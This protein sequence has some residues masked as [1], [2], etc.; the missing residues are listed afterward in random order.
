MEFNLQSKF[1]LKTILCALFTLFSLFSF[2]QPGSMSNNTDCDGSYGNNA[3]TTVGVGSNNTVFTYREQANATTSSGTKFY[4]FNADGYFNVWNLNTPTYN[5]VSTAVWGTGGYNGTIKMGATVSSSYYTFN[6]RKGTSYASQNMAILETAFLPQNITAVSVPSN[7]YG[8]QTAT[9]SVTMSG[10]LNSSE[11]LYVA[12]STDAFATSGN[13]GCVA[14]GAL[15]GSFVGNATIPAQISGTV[16]YYAFSSTS[17]S[18]PSF[19]NIP[20]LTLNMRNATA[21]NTSAAYASYTIQPWTTQTGATTFSAGSSWVGGVAP[22]AGVNIG[23]L[24]INH[25]LALDQDIIS[26][27]VAIAN[28]T[29][30]TINNGSTLQ[31]A[32]GITT[33]GTGSLLVNG[34]LQ[35]NSGGFSNV[36]PTYG[37]S[38]L[39]KYNSGTSYGRGTEWSATTGAGYPN[40]VQINNSTTLNLGANAG[41]GTARQCSGNL[42]IN[43]GSTLSMNE[44][45]AVMTAALTVRGDVINNGTITL[46]G[47]GG[48]DLILFGNLDD[49]GS[50]FA[51]TRA[52]FFDGSNTQT[53]NSSTDP[54]DIDVMRVR[55][56]GGEIILAQNLVVDET[57]DPFQVSTAASVINLNGKN[58]TI[59]KSG[60]TSAIS[61]ISGSAIKCNVASS[62]II[63]GNGALGTLRFDPSNNTLRNLTIN[64]GTSRTVT[65]GSALN[66]TSGSASGI[67]TVG[68]GSTLNTGGFLTLK[69]DVSGTASIGNS[70][71]TISGDVTAERYISGA[72][73]KWRFLSTPVVGQTLANWGSQF[74]ITGPGTAGATI[75]SANSNGFATTR[76]NLL[77]IPTTTSSVRRYVESTAGDLNVGWTDLGSNTSASLT[78]GVG[79]RVFIRGPI[80][81]NYSIDTLAIGSSANSQDQALFTLNQTGSITNTVNAGT[82]NLPVTFT[83][84]NGTANDGWNLVGNPYPSNID[85]NASGWTKTAV[86]GTFYIYSPTL[87]VYGSY[88]GLT[89]VNSIN[90]YIPSGQSFFVK[91]TAASPVLSLTESVKVSNTSPILLKTGDE[92]NTLRIKLF[93]DSMENDETVIRFYEGKNDEFIDG[94]DV[95]K[96][97]NEN[98]NV[99]SSFG[100]GVYSMVNYLSLNSLT[101]K[102]VK[103][104]AWVS[105]PGSYKMEFNQTE[106]F[107]TNVKIYLRDNYKNTVTNLRDIHTYTF[108]IDTSKASTQDG[109]LEI[110]F[111]DKAYTSTLENVSDGSDVIV[112]P[113]PAKDYINIEFV[114]SKFTNSKIQV[115]DISGKEYFNIDMKSESQKINIENLVSGVYFVKITNNNGTNKTVKFVK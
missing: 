106:D 13:S 11:Y 46:S 87:N 36:A 16:T 76:S 114:N 8:G 25:S 37:S 60:T 91:A 97:V 55:K 17:S 21:Q 70:A 98:V 110:I 33:P 30:L 81:G 10:A 65:L 56:T 112:F 31:M 49:N 74:Y 83:S 41:T 1:S 93:K 105:T 52:I 15:N 19:A 38:S 77:G 111:T 79:Y 24:A 42:T 12:W 9:V 6:I 109:R 101:N 66:I 22:S 80:T 90:R 28:G 69:S 43:S 27:G 59:G 113:N 78:P 40:N 102:V 82:V 96:F 50:F 26:S 44:S 108:K 63:A 51:N 84:N 61:M 29:T 57:G 115:S 64:A 54:L 67:V 32:G 92:L 3:M 4:Q 53:I 89:G 18:A 88:D 68:S 107:D 99:A 23:A 34:T 72:G 75:G 7:V 35:I 58:L 104:A 85:W 20:L 62:I 71:G 86:S 94:E 100:N 2:A 39:L 14:V 103:M 5:T 73:R 47:S 48:G 45:G 95:S